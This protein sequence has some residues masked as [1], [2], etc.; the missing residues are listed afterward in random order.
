MSQ[1]ADSA[2]V[3]VACTKSGDKNVRSG[4]QMHMILHF[5]IERIVEESIMSAKGILHFSDVRLSL[6]I[7]FS[8]HCSELKIQCSTIR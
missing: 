7:P 2:V 1:Q 6:C 8:K 5:T 3:I 4:K